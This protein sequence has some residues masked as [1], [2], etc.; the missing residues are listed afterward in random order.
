MVYRF[1]REKTGRTLFNKIMG[2]LYVVYRARSECTY[3]QF[4]VYLHS[5]EPMVCINYIQQSKE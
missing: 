2:V 5:P 3:E 4:D 1:P